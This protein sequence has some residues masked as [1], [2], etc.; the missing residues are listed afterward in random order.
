[1]AGNDFY[2]DDLIRQRDRA[3]RIKMGPG[4]EPN[5]PREA[6]ADD[7]LGRPISDLNLTRMARHKQD[8]DSQ[9]TR[10][11]QELEALRKR[12]EQLELEKRDLEEFKRKSEEFERGKR[13]VIA[14]IKR[15]L[16]AIERDEIEAQRMQELLQ[17]TRTRFKALLS[18]L[19]DI[20]EQSWT[21][22][23]IREELTRALGMIEDARIEYNRSVAKIDGVKSER[24]TGSSSSSPAP[25]L[26]DDHG[27]GFENDKSF[28]QWLKIGAAFSLPLI[29]TF[30]ILA[31]VYMG[32]LMSG[33]W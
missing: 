9:A 13:D 23:N 19:E 8:V 22:D 2:D 6:N 33:A 14:N 24:S 10:A 7:G 29:I 15:S 32:M 3:N 5:P 31:V 1:M 30:V 18:G 21:D 11:M 16:T 28:S 20:K 4:D 25:V 12:Q 26:F 27:V 17:G